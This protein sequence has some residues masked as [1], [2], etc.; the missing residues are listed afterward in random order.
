MYQFH[1]Y[2]M[3]N[4]QLINQQIQIEKDQR[5]LRGFQEAKKRLGIRDQLERK[6]RINKRDLQRQ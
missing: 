2:I 5:N 1:N 4:I 3:D 6:K